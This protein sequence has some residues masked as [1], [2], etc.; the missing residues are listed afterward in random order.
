MSRI[1]LKPIA[2]PRGVSVKTDGRNVHVE[3][4][5]G[6]LTWEHHS[7]VKVAV[8]G[9]SVKVERLG[10]D[11]LSRALHGTTRQLVQNMIT[12]VS[13]GF[14]RALDIVGV[15]YNAKLDK[16]N[17]VLQIGFCHPVIL[18][19]PAGVVVEVPQPTRLVI[20]GSDRQQV[21]QFSAEI[22]GVRPPEPYKGKGI[23]YVTEIVRRKQ[24]KSLGS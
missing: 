17:L 24:A 11:K 7:R 16:Q 21:G 15:G 12:G 4:P 22:R 2:L 18:P 1:G 9:G 20:K 8:D 5:K 19:I 6:K 14:E 10:S 13:T 3:G 23:R